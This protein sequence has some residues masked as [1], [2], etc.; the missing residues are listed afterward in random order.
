MLH[1]FKLRE[2]SPPVSRA[3][4][5][6]TARSLRKQ[7]P[8]LYAI[9]AV[10][11]IGI[12]YVLPPAM[13]RVLKFGP[14]GFLLFIVCIHL[15]SWLRLN[16]RAPTVEEAL[17]HCSRARVLIMVLNAGA[18]AWIVAAFDDMDISLRTPVSLLVSMGAVASAYCLRGFPSAARLIVL[19]TALPVVLQLVF[20]RETTLICTGI[21]LSLFVVLLIGVMNADYRRFAKLIAARTK[22]LA[23]GNRI[24][25]AEALAREREAKVKEIAA[26]FDTALNNMSQGLCFFDGAQRLIV[27]NRRYIDMYGLSPDVVHPGMSLRQIAEIGFDAGWGPDLTKEA[28]L[29]WLDRVAV[30]DRPAITV[31]ELKNG[32][33]YEIRHQPMPDRGWVATHEDVTER[34][35][36]ERAL[37]QAKASAERAEREARAAHVTLL[38]ALDIIPEGLVIFDADD[39][40]VLWNRRYAEIY[41]ESRDVLAVGTRFEDTLR[42]G[43]E[44][45]QYPD[46]KGRDKNG[47]ANDW[48]GTRNPT[49][50]MSNN[51]RATAG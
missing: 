12:A 43:L 47:Y 8:I 24:R 20:S 15:I 40:Y 38:N 21:N 23:D 39:R 9:L 18:L 49:A 31:L 1:C 36:T 7:L 17:R 13:P 5:V 28:F 41:A 48:L 3:L 32:R 10:N 33:F 51:C 6:E 22:M 26:R 16:A 14:P 45:G 37:T 42:A 29:G 35:Q 34:Y 25:R 2:T 27:C 19:V 11:S 50:H 30:I 46:A 44:R 4:L